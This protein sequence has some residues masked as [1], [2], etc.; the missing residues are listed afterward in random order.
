M[1]YFL[2]LLL[3]LYQTFPL[4]NAKIL[5]Y[6]ALKG[7]KPRQYYVTLPNKSFCFYGFVSRD[8]IVLW[9][10]L[11]NFHTCINVCGPKEHK[12][13]GHFVPSESD[14]FTCAKSLSKL[15]HKSLFHSGVCPRRIKSNVCALNWCGWKRTSMQFWFSA[16][17]PTFLFLQQ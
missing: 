16:G 11:G 15:Y 13:R 4:F 9:I 14:P 1:L 10:H 6:C 7:S 3:C 5:H 2:L 17:K 12:N 8:K